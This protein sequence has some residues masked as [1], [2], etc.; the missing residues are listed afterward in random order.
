MTLDMR[1]FKKL[2]F[3]RPDLS[4]FHP[5][6]LLYPWRR[7]P[8]NESRGE[9][10]LRMWGWGFGFWGVVALNFVSAVCLTIPGYIAAHPEAM[11]SI[12][13]A[14]AVWALTLFVDGYLF[15]SQLDKAE[16][17]KRKIQYQRDEVA[18]R[19]KRK[20][21]EEEREREWAERH[22]PQSKSGW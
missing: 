8:Q 1:K 4:A 18:R 20:L 15:F 16:E 6:V 21:E 2:A 9:W 3:K 5:V 7:R 22:P 13:L 14:V 17:I 12:A 10:W 11:G 19:R